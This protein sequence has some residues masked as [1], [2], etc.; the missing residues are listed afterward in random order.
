MADRPLR[1]ATRLR[2][3]EP[4]PHQLP[5]RPRDHTPA[6]D[7]SS[8]DHAVQREYPVLIQ[9]SLG[10]PD[11]GGRFLTCYAPVRRFPRSNLTER[12]L[13]PRLACIKRTA[14][15]RPEP[16][17]N[18]PSKFFDKNRS[19]VCASTDQECFSSLKRMRSYEDGSSMCITVGLYVH[20]SFHR[21]SRSDGHITLA[22]RPPSCLVW[23]QAP[24]NLDRPSC[25]DR[26]THCSVVKEPGSHRVQHKAARRGA[27]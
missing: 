11:L 1:P 6:A 10:Y 17:S 7:F 26:S 13:L 18:S 5:D 9:V 25:D 12:S 8:T 22:V 27:S 14:N 4:L 21:S 3:G 19:C 24:V 2:L 20:R 16:G 23:R 15:V